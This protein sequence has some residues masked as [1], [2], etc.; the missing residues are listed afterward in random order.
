MDSFFD[1][2]SCLNDFDLD[3]GCLVTEASMDLIDLI[4]FLV[5]LI[6]PFNGVGADDSTKHGLDALWGLLQVFDVSLQLLDVIAQLLLVLLHLL[7]LILHSKRSAL[8]LTSKAQGP[9]LFQPEQQRVSALTYTQGTGTFSIS[10]WAAMG[11]HFDSLLRYSDLFYLILHG[12]GSALS[13]TC[14][15]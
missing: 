4:V 12:K 13:L 9:I 11:Q 3:S 7:Y 5:V 14:K 10:S 8:W 6:L 1:P 15:A 2:F